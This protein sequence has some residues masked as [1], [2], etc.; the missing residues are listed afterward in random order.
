[1]VTFF[2]FL[3]ISVVVGNIWARNVRDVYW[4]KNRVMTLCVAA[5]M[6]IG[7][8][9]SFLGGSF[10]KKEII[11]EKYVISPMIF[12]GKPIVALT[13]EGSSYVFQV[14]EN[15]ET[16]IRLTKRNLSK[17]EIF[18]TDD[19]EERCLEIKR[20]KVCRRRMW[21]W[22]FYS[23]SIESKAMLKKGD[24]FLTLPRYCSL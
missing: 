5:G 23:I 14:K 13:E 2:V 4:T 11:V 9:A 15:N 18:F 3:M 21:V 17:E 24:S 16:E 7:V 10:V 22:F 1:M 6:F 19:K 8:G 12:D 20:S